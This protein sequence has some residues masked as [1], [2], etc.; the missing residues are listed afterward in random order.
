MSDPRTNSAT[1]RDALDAHFEATL[2]KY[3]APIQGL[4]NRYDSTTQL[5]D[6]QTVVKL[7]IQGIEQTVAP[8][9]TDVSV[10]FPGGRDHSHT[11]PLFVGDGMTLIPQD[12]DVGAYLA[13][14]AVY[15][16]PHSDRRFSLSDAIGFPLVARPQG[17]VLPPE[18]MAADGAVL[19]G[20][21]YVGSGLATQFAA[22]AD[23]ADSE[24]QKVLDRVESHVHPSNG[25]PPTPQ[26]PPVALASTACTKLKVI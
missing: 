6:V 12:A 9:I 18:A 13:S 15:Q 24:L 20:L 1:W 14:G 7:T 10:A 26:I 17:A 2:Q 16:Q 23:K 22:R 3:H 5:A 11:W 8:I 4:I 19:R 25:S 21:T